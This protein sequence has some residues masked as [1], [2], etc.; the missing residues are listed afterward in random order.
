MPNF[1]ENLGFLCVIYNRIGVFRA[2]GSDEK[3]PDNL[4]GCLGVCVFVQQGYPNRPK[5]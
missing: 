5:H 2:G 4:I 3:D 1:G